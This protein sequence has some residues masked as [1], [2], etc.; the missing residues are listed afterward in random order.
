MLRV[1]LFGLAVA[2]LGAPTLESLEARIVALENHEHDQEDH[3]HHSHGG[4]GHADEWGGLFHLGSGTYSWTFAKNADGVYGANDPAMKVVV[5]RAFGDE[6]QSAAQLLEAHHDEAEL[7]L[8][9][10]CASLAGG[11]TFVPGDAC[12]NLV[13]DAAANT[14]QFVLSVAAAGRFVAFTEHHPNEFGAEA[15][16]TP[17]GLMAGPIATYTHDTG[18]DD[19]DHE[20]EHAQDVISVAALVLACLSLLIALASFLQRCSSVG[21]G[22]RTANNVARPMTTTMEMQTSSATEGVSNG[23]PKI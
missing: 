17:A 5:L 7:L 19:H 20:H 23:H 22:G 11:G 3:S 9:G 16:G 18:H 6:Q 4:D 2:A 12:V 13:F 14:T 21:R 10:T 1:S 15:L 8:R